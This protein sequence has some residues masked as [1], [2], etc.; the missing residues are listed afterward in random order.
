[1]FIL[2]EGRQV[3][4]VVTL[5]VT[6][7]WFSIFHSFQKEHS[8]KMIIFVLKNNSTKSLKAPLNYFSWFWCIFHIYSYISRND[9]SHH[10]FS[11]LTRHTQTSFISGHFLITPIQ[12]FWI[13]NDS[14]PFVLLIRIVSC[15]TRMNQKYTNWLSHLGSSK[16]YSSS[17]ISKRIFKILNYFFSISVLD[18]LYYTSNLKQ[19]W[20]S[21]L[22]YRTYH[23]DIQI[24]IKHPLQ[25]YYFILH[26]LLRGLYSFSNIPSK[27]AS[28][29]FGITMGVTLE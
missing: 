18:I 13:D 28:L 21:Y 7:E 15:R 27:P 29:S 9:D 25:I 19:Y 5:P 22:H 17:G 10:S 11:V 4:L 23:Y 1:M 20:I 12:Y 16:S 6:P 3:Y 24:A 26:V 2:Y 14:I 8:L